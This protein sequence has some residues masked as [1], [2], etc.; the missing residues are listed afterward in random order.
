MNTSGTVVGVFFEGIPAMAA[1]LASY[2]KHRLWMASYA[3][4]DKST[5][6]S[7]KSAAKRIDVRLVVSEVTTTEVPD[8]GFKVKKVHTDRGTMHSKFIVAD[9]QV[10]VGSSNFS[11]RSKDAAVLLEGTVV[12]HFVAEFR[13]LEKLYQGVG[14]LRGEEAAQLISSAAAIQGWSRFLVTVYKRS[15]ARGYLT[16]GE[17]RAVRKIIKPERRK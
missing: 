15:Q 2:S 4:P 16:T 6:Q 5:L 8:L 17:E 9:E 1:H 12:K 3:L 13:K 10:L 7:M 11:G 14:P